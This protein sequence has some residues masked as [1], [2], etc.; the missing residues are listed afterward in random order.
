M[1][2]K[3]EVHGQCLLGSCGCH[4]GSGLNEPHWEYLGQPG[5]VL[6]VVGEGHVPPGAGSR[7]RQTCSGTACAILDYEGTILA[8][9]G[10]ILARGLTSIIGSTWGST[11]GS[12]GW[13]GRVTCAPGSRHV[14]AELEVALP[15]PYWI[16]VGTIL[17][18]GGAIRARGLMSL[19]GST[20][21][22]PWVSR[23]QHGRVTY[24]PGWCHVTSEPEVARPTPSWIAAGSILARGG[25]ILPWG[26]MS[27]TGRIWDVPGRSRGRRERVSCPS[28]GAGSCDCR[29]GSGSARAI[30]ARVSAVSSRV[31]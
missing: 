11:G 26:L 4:P 6:W 1:T 16:A 19:I 30:N 25:T 29:S 2:A 3:P 9:G 13:C 18:R 7:D 23:G 28:P 8:R 31:F 15:A 17:L 5:L 21:G 14:T 10:P 24:S 12:P 22:D 20:W 27:L